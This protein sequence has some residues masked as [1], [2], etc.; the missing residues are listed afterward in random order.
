[1]TEQ[2]SQDGQEKQSADI[3]E[4]ARIMEMLPHRYPFLLLDRV[5][6]I[7]PSESA[8]G[9]KNVT[10]SEP[11]FQGHFPSHPVT[12]GV[13]I[14]ETMAQTA[15]VLVIHSLGAETEGKLVYF[16]TVDKA[17]FRKPVVPGDVMKVHV[18]K[19][20]ARGKIWKFAGRVMVDGKL[21]AEAEFSAMIRDA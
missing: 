19:V 6:D 10:I 18:N 17:R 5:E 12:P 4:I 13:L 1:M 11:H 15:A 9:I 14:V 2:E 8:V 3:L 20:H 21:A 7:V 16:M